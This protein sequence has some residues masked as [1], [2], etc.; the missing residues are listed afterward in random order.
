MPCRAALDT[1]DK[2]C[3]L[4]SW[5]TSS[6]TK[7]HSPLVIERCQ[8]SCQHRDYRTYLSEAKRPNLHPHTFYDLL[9]STLYNTRFA[10]LTSLADLAHQWLEIGRASCRASG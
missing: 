2:R 10:I 4:Y 1:I 3:C 6:I 8:R 9:Q 5:C 7:L